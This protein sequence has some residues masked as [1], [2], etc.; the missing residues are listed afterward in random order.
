MGMPI[1]HPPALRPGTDPERP[2]DATRLLSVRGDTIAHRRI[3]ALPAELTP[4]DLLV[5]NDAATLP[6]SLRGE[7]RGE[8]I[9]V[10]IAAGVGPDDFPL[11]M[12]VVLFGA[13]DWRMDTDARPAPPPAPEGARLR[14]DGLE[15]TVTERSSISP[16]LVR[17]RWSCQGDA[18]A[19]ALYR[20]GA[21]VQYRHLRSALPLAAVQTP[22]AAR[23]WAVE[24]PSTGRPLSWRLLDALRNHG[25]DHAFLTHAAGLSATG[26]PALDRAL[27]LP[28]RYEIP[29]AT[30]TTVL[31][32]RARGG[33]VIAVGTTVAR[34]LESA[35]LEGSRPGAGTATLRIGPHH[36]RRLVDGILTGIHAPGESHFELLGAFATRQTLERAHA[37][38]L[39]GGYLAHELGDLMLLLPSHDG[40][41][42]AE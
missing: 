7:L 32:T 28:E 21:V 26:D 40:R 36:E 10:R 15:A 9:E 31:E 27:P 16:R 6:A 4:G 23:P 20:L 42:L 39:W 38:A 11:D 13:G 8:P 1:A 24:M 33:R 19:S 12:W 18:L 22:Y 30:L 34:A 37:A 3:G 5:L 29:A 14:F 35:A 25:I 2:L 17:V 41:G